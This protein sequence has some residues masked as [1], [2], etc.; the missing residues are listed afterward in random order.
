MT[1]SLHHRLER[2]LSGSGGSVAST[3]G[4]ALERPE[5]E[6]AAHEIAGA[7]RIAE[8]RL[9]EPV[10]V[11]IRNRPMDLAALF[12]VWLAGG[13]A[14]PV[15]G[16]AARTTAQAVR[17]A[18]GSRFSLDGRELEASASRPPPDR[19][20]LDGAALIVFTSGS[21]GRPK[22]VVIG[23]DG[24]SGK[25]DVLEALLR[26]GADD[27]VVVPL[28]LTFIFGLWASLLTL[29]SGARL[30]LVPRFSP[31]AVGRALGE[32][33]TV[34]VAVP[35]MLRALLSGPRG[36]G[37]G[38]RT[39]LTGGEAL[40]PP[41][42]GALREAFPSV[43]IHDL[44]GLTET[45]SCDFCL[46]PSDQPAGL[47]SIGSPTDQVEFRIVGEAGAP[48]PAGEAGELHIRTPFGMSGYLDNP[49]LTRDSFVDGFFRTGDIARRRPDGRVELVGRS[50]EIISRGGN[51]IAP[52]ELDNLLASHPEV[53]AALCTGVADE[54]LGEAIHAI[55]VLKPG[56]TLTVEALRRWAGLHI[57]RYK[58]P[59]AIHVRDA[60]PLG[61]TGKA[62]RSAAA[63]LVLGG[64][65]APES[66]LIARRPGHKT[67]E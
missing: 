45:G 47:G 61:S 7:L 59:D 30:I 3:P 63:D 48:V 41:L 49:E 21:T 33:G 39:V 24:F 67:K 55:V 51:K 27:T 12:G 56:S 65:S 17:D 18:T 42:A 38:P 25:L 60:I 52:L 29:R 6:Q 36:P 16:A 62:S 44:Y 5:L 13:V 26:F 57:E 20:L 34:L 2:I 66:A 1:R 8:V 9:H 15:H 19:P 31:E 32:G 50:K 40:G 10:L 64:R 53:A 35:S 58:L 11:T 14:V 28:Q 37:A 4:E 54:R 43:A 23:H 22:G 46:R